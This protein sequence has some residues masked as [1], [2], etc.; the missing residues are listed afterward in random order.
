MP[1]P[2]FIIIGTQKGGTSS[3]YNALV[4]HPQILKAAR[5][6]VHFFDQY[7]ERG[8]DWYRQ[9]FPACQPG[10]VTGEASPFYMAHPRVAERIARD[11]PDTRLI[12]M[13]RN[14]ADRAISHYQQEYRR[15]HDL[16]DL[17]RALAEEDARTAKDWAALKRGELLTR[18][19]AQRFSYRQRGYYARQLAPYFALFPRSRIFILQSEAYFQS[20]YDLLPGIYRF[21]GV[22][23]G[24]RPADLSI[25]K[26]GHYEKILDA[27]YHDL[28]EHYAQENET[29]F[30][31]IGERYNW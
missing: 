16:A 25:R 13:L 21:L 8:L 29:L 26:P 30:D 9:Q 17:A 3:L 7:Y 5:K 19:N 12:V 20:P 1:L 18:S 4:Q 31:M 28:M 14:P 27:I 22:D 15:K 10:Q 11:C 23:P 2:D 6:E 24:F